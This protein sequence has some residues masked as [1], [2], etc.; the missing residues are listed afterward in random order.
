MTSACLIRSY[1]PGDAAT[2][3]EIFCRAVHEIASAFYTEEQCLAWSDRAPNMPHWEKRC[4]RKQPFVA[5]VGD[6]VAGFLEL[7]PDG[8]IDCAYVHPD[9]QRRGMMTALVQHALAVAKTRRNER[10]YVEASLCAKPLF[11][12]LGFANLGENVVMIKGATLV[13][14]TMAKEC[15]DR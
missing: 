6:R 5:V 15:S 1:Q 14:Y 9:F 2:I 10:V 11:E 13:N 8:H 3:A 4:E 12:K 7:E